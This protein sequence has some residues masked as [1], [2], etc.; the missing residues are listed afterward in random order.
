M[1]DDWK[2]ESALQ[3][4]ASLRSLVCLLSLCWEHY[5]CSS[6]FIMLLVK[7]RGAEEERRNEDLSGLACLQ[8]DWV[9]KFTVAWGSRLWAIYVLVFYCFSF[10]GVTQSSLHWRKKL[11]YFGDRNTACLL[12][13]SCFSTCYTVSRLRPS[14]KMHLALTADLVARWMTSGW[15]EPGGGKTA[16][17][18]C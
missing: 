7:L 17:L 12:L 2:Q 1:D 16:N 15:R 13:S 3:I 8:W 11:S 18:L 4:A 10:T 9:R 14:P 6:A 5:P